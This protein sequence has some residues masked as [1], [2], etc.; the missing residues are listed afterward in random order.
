MQVGD[1][2]RYRYGQRDIGIIIEA[3]ALSEYPKFKVAWLAD[4]EHEWMRSTG[5]EVL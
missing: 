5:L 4:D 1:L 3:N 2:V